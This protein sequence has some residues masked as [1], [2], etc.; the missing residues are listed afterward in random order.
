MLRL[1]RNFTKAQT[2]KKHS[3]RV[4]IDRKTGDYSTFRQ[5]EVVADEDHEMPACQD[6]ISDVDPAEMVD[7]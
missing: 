5:W 1:K 7:W 3:L 4:E 6:A 2:R